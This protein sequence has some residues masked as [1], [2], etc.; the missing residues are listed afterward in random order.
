M[1]CEGLRLNDAEILAT[2]DT[3]AYRDARNGPLRERGRDP[4][5][6]RRTDT[7]GEARLRACARATTRPI[8]VEREATHRALSLAEVVDVPV[9][10][11]YVSNGAARGELRAARARRHK[12]V[13]ETCRQYL[14][15]TAADLDG[16]DWKGAKS[17]V[18]RRHAAKPSRTPTGPGWKAGLQ[19]RLVRP[20]PCP[21]RRSRRQAEP[22]GAANFR[23]VPKGVP[24]VETR[25]P[26]LFSEGVMA[27]RI[28]PRRFVALAAINHAKP[29][30]GQKG[31]DRGGNGCRHR[32]LGSED[33]PHYSPC[34]SP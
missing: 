31:L 26:I 29:W 1:T 5:S 25:L 10:I 7:E 32:D 4:L 23:H 2:M 8:V 17:S 27:G 34:L 20:L 18:R 12:V 15:L 28:N 21:L 3:A 14:M 11:V 19:S 22:K 9:V 33:P 16:M 6:H 13:G 24:G 30:A